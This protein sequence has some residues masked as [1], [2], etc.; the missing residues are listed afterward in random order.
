MAY[1]SNTLAM[2]MTGGDTGRIHVRTNGNGTYGTWKKY[3]HDGDFTTT[4]V[5]N[6]NTA[7]GWGDHGLSAQDKTDIGNL[8]GTNT[9]DQTNISGNAA[10]ADYA[11]TAGSAPNASNLNSSYGVSAG[12]GRGL[13]FWNGADTYKIAMGNA[14]EY[15][16]GP[17]TDYSIKMVMDSVNSTRGFTWGV[18]GATP[19]AGLNVGNG[20]ME[21]AGTFTASNFSGT[22]SGTNTGD[23][24]NVSGN[25]ATA[26]YATTAGSASNIDNVGF[27]NSN[28]GN[29]QAADSINN[30]GISYVSG[31][32]NL[33]GNAS[34]GALYSQAYSSQWQH[35]IYGDYR[36]G[37]IWVRGK[38][39]NTWQS[40]KKVALVNSTT[41]TNVLGVAFTHGLDTKNL[42]VQV[43]DTN[44]NLFFPSDINVTDTE[45]NIDF[46]KPRS[47][48][49]VVTG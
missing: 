26:T 49:V 8:S 25:A 27:T 3:W 13:K 34:D 14:A 17:V 32:P 4:N 46:A 28:S 30:N 39:S 19:I 24:T 12:D 10:T 33:S 18:N 2:S 47:G 29:A 48:R 31:F 16:Y 37:G 6:W 1:Y 42:V 41:F 7:Y 15:H 45:V 11:T 40:W 38:N 22:S 20:N 9:G 43:Y 23:Q 36:V 5:S 44:D 21:I 35:Q